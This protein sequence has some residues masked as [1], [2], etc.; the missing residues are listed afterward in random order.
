[1]PPA[2]RCRKLCQ[3]S[4]SG[5]SALAASLGLQLAFA[6]RDAS[7]VSGVPVRRFR[8]LFPLA[9]WFWGG[10]SRFG[11]FEPAFDA[12]DAPVHV[13]GPQSERRRGL[14]YRRQWRSTGLMRR[15]TLPRR[16]SK[17]TKTLGRV[18]GFEPTT[19]RST[20]WRSNQLSY[21]RRREWR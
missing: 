16:V 3:Q 10:S 13:V 20:I 6:A 5:A 15:T 1:M 2:W 7:A 19:S 8:H 21:T 9:V 18:I 17:W 12:L 4:A 14:A 11:P